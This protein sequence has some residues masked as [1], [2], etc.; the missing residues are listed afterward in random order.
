VSTML[1]LREVQF[2]N[3]QSEVGEASGNSA[4]SAA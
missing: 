1:E 4:Q 3:G 2:G